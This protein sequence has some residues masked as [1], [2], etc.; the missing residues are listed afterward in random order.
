MYFFCLS[1]RSFECISEIIYEYPFERSSG[2][3]KRG[4][5]QRHLYQWR[6]FCCSRLANGFA[7]GFATGL[8]NGFATPPCIE[9]LAS[10]W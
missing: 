7:T 6:C 3:T 1:G 2:A 10:A 8:A 4:A 5:C 9:V